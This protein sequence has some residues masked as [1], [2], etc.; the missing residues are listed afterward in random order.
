MGAKFCVGTGS[1]TQALSTCVEALG[2]GPGDEV[3]TSPYTDFGRISSIICSNLL[4]KV[5]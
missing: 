3:I 5:I 2:I 4:E 1:G